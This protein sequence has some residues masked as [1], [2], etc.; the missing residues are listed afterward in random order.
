MTSYCPVKKTSH[1]TSYETL[2][3]ELILIHY[4]LWLSP[5]FADEFLNVIGCGSLRFRHGWQISSAVSE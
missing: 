4:G 2:K 5:S 1:G 3:K